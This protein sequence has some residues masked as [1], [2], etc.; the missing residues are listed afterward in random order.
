LLDMATSEKH[1]LRSRRRNLLGW[2]KSLKKKYH[3]D[4]PYAKAVKLLALSLFDQ[5][6]ALHGLGNNE[7]LLLEIA[8]R[9]H[10]IGM[11]VRVGGHH[12]HAAY[13][14]MA[15]PLLGISDAEKT[16]LAQTVRYQRKAFPDEG[17]E[18]FAALDKTERSSVCCLS[19][20]LRLAIALNKDR[21]NRVATVRVETDEKHLTLH[22]EGKGNLLLERWAVLKTS[23]YVTR[24]FNRSL[25][26]DLNV[27]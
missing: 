20:I 2:A 10:E 1:L 11:Y 5:T 23:D 16:I 6:R 15:A 13:L 24:A 3:V 21:R 9:V 12:R 8:A 27:D 26:I 4:Q 22:L 14:I 7:R 19:A 25:N 17:H 18:T